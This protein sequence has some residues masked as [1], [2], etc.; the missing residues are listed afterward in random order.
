MGCMDSV[1]R[2]HLNKDKQTAAIGH[3]LLAVGKGLCQ[4]VM[5]N[6]TTRE[7]LSA[8]DWQLEPELSLPPQGEE[9]VCEVGHRKAQIG[10]ARGV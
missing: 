8:N 9:K 4:Y 3:W 2:W 6:D 1:I 5:Q 10:D 7:R